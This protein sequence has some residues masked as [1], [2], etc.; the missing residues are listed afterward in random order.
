MIPLLHNN[1]SPS[2]LIPLL[3]RILIFFSYSTQIN[4]LDGDRWII[5]CTKIVEMG[6]DGTKVIK[7]TLRGMF[8]LTICNLTPKHTPTEISDHRILLQTM[9][10]HEVEAK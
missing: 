1:S 8:M 9:C 10:W 3:R 7:W 4:I 2:L 6:E 5:Y